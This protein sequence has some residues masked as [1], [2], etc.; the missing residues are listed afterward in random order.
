MRRKF[1]SGILFIAFATS[2]F[3]GAQDDA[4]E[5]APPQNTPPAQGG[6]FSYNPDAKKV[7][8]GVILIKGATPSASDSMTAVPEGGIIKEQIYANSY[9]GMAFP[10]PADWHQKYLGPPPSDSGYYVLT[11]VEPA[12]ISK[13]QV[14]GT[15]LVSAQDLFFPL[16]PVN[17]ALDLVNFKRDRLTAD[18]KVEQQPAE[19]KIAGRSFIRMDYMSPVAELHWHILATQVR[20]HMVEFLFTSRDP[21]MIERLMQDMSKMVVMREGANVGHGG[22]EAPVCVKDY[23]SGNNVTNQV[24]PSFGERKF[25]PVPVRIIIGKNGKV[26]YVHVISAF[27]EQSR[28]ITDA[29]LQ[30]EFKPYRVNGQPVEV[31]TG[32]MFGAPP[33]PNQERARTTAAE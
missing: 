8:Q 1:L 9:F 7:P 19:V 16:V 31:E 3:A 23:A 32:I 26:K 18:F 2:L 11:Q 17:T 22:G 24:Q 25:N 30:W 13:D 15:I 27:P 20:C 33:R 5:P 29:L 14:S 12:K 28:A 6:D 10:L 21:A 4:K